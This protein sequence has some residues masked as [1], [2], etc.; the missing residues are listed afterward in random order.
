MSG[1]ITNVPS[2]VVGQMPVKEALKA[3]VSVANER[4]NEY[5]IDRLA[6]YG[7]QCDADKS[8]AL[9]DAATNCYWF[10]N[11]IMVFTHGH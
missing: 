11:T 4:S 1:K 7:W 9:R 3:N 2:P 6:Q 5:I 8:Q 10:D